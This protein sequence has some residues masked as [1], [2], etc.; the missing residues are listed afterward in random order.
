MSETNGNR[1][2]VRAGTGTAALRPTT[3]DEWSAYVDVISLSPGLPDGYR[4]KNR[5]ETYNPQE[6]RAL[7]FQAMQ[8]GAEL[9]MTPTQSIASI[10]M[11]N[12]RPTLWGDGLIGVVRGSGVCGYIKETVEGDGDAMV[13]TCEAKR[14][15]TDEVAT[16]TFS[17]ADAQAAG[18]FDR[19]P[20]YKA[21][22]K[23]MCQMRARALCLRDLF[24]DVLRGIKAVSD[25]YEAQEYDLDMQADGT[26]VP[27]EKPQRAEAADPP[28][29]TV[30]PARDKTP[31]TYTVFD[32]NG[33]TV[34]DGVA[35]GR[36]GDMVCAMIGEAG[37]DFES[38]YA[39]NLEWLGAAKQKSK[40]DAA[41]EEARAAAEQSGSAAAGDA[42]D[43]AAGAP[44]A[45]GGNGAVVSPAPHTLRWSCP[46]AP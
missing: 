44:E 45:G 12:G 8:M 25:S 42:N 30:A 5:N 46:I 38:V 40:A 32:E 39:N 14:S 26:F 7:I 35:A 3:L 13:A 43:P 37:A 17:M 6:T 10:A 18:L 36:A 19:N 21:Y 22:G 31:K 27:A 23:R 16:R 15:D 41:L 11:I 2:V 9:G 4:Q 20:V 33:E 29:E 34:A 28:A 24:A 1:A